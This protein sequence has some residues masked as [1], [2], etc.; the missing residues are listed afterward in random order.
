MDD[1]SLL[2][3]FVKGGDER[4]FRDLVARH[5]DLVY[6]SA[7]RQVR[8]SHLAEDVTQAVFIL[9]AR[10]ADRVKS[11]AALPAWLVA[12]ARYVA[13]DLIRAE[14]RRRRR[15]TQAANM[16]PM[17]SDESHALQRDQAALVDDALARL[18]EPD[19]VLVTLR[20]LKG[21]SITEVAATAGRKTYV[22]P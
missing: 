9:L 14:A 18:R 16:M 19:R 13:R 15:E 1:S 10:K 8:D 22:R 6:A 3:A 2:N 11:A 17:V 5:V 20:Y 7:R 4:A 21:M 12:T